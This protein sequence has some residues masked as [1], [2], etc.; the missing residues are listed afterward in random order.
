MNSLI[1][2][3]VYG[4]IGKIKTLPERVV[5]HVEGDRVNGGATVGI[6]VHL[7]AAT[8]LHL[9]E[10]RAAGQRI[11]AHVVIENDLPELSKP[12][13]WTG[14]RSIEHTDGR[15]WSVSEDGSIDGPPGV[16]KEVLTGFRQAGLLV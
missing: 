7:D 3:E 13:S 2:L 16:P 1:K 9:K 10:R 14:T 6:G 8:A 4:T 11:R 12:F 15:L 5:T